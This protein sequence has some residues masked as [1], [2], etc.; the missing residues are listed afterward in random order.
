[1]QPVIKWN[2]RYIAYAKAH[3]KSPDEMLASQKSMAGFIIWIG[4]QVVDFREAHPE[5]FV[6]SAIRDHEAFNSF[7]GV[8]PCSS[9]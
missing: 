1:M 7:L 5:A 8:G 4:E 2:P 6:G 9:H 3:G